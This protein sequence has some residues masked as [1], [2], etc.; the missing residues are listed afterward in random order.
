MNQFSTRT[1]PKRNISRLAGLA[2]IWL[3]GTI[4]SSTYSQAPDPLAS[5]D[6]RKQDLEEIAQHESYF[7]QELALMRLVDVA[8]TDELNDMLDQSENLASTSFQN[9]VRSVAIHKLATNAPKKALE[10]ISD[11]DKEVQT[12]LVTVVYQEWSVLDLE[13]AIAFMHDLGAPYQKAALQGIL[14]SREDLGSERLEEIALEFGLE[15]I[16]DDLLAESMGQKPIDNPKKA[17]DELIRTFPDNLFDIEG[18]QLDLVAHV[19]N[20]NW[21]KDGIKALRRMYEPIRGRPGSVRLMHEF[22]DH[23]AD[24]DPELALEVA[25]DLDQN[26]DDL[27][28]SQRILRWARD[29]PFAALHAALTTTNK[30]LRKDFVMVYNLASAPD[31]IPHLMIEELKG[32]PYEVMAMVLS[33]TMYKLTYHSPQLASQ[34]LYLAEDYR[35]KLKMA[36][37]IAET[38]SREDSLAALNWATSAQEVRDMRDQ[39][40]VVVM[41]EMTKFDPELA[42]EVALTQSPADTDIGPEA[43]VIEEFSTVNFDKAMDL[44]PRVRN[45][46]TMLSAAFSLGYRAIEIGQ[47]S[48]LQD[49]AQQLAESDRSEFFESLLGYWVSFDPNGLYDGLETL[50]SSKLKSSAAESLYIEN[51]ASGRTLLDDEQRRMVESYLS[52]EDLSR[53]SKFAQ[54]L[55]NLRFLLP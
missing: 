5:P 45:S 3:V 42:F 44:L 30:N 37:H 2:S 46:A 13:A 34:Y 9:I 39:L 15:A 8:S 28:A 24:H 6:S 25:I 12:P 31:V 26:N 10:R 17:W 23:L 32:Y 53:L 20:S 16:T 55:E 41:R 21:E 54:E 36:E 27:M 40:L 50:P 48:T 49:I 22:I 38:W 18:S 14:D 51:E 33:S 11:W 1:K 43:A 35:E 52:D 7:A 4:T 29:D 19:I 47:S